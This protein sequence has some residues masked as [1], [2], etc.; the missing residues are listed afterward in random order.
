MTLKLCFLPFLKYILFP[1][2]YKVPMS[3]PNQPY[4]FKKIFRNETREHFGYLYKKG[5]WISALGI[6]KSIFIGSFGVVGD[7][8][9][10][11]YQFF[12]SQRIGLDI[13]DQGDVKNICSFR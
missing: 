13:H 1:S 12:G 3:G 2:R 5:S 6:G 10:P 9:R 7:D 11:S 4:F 8:P